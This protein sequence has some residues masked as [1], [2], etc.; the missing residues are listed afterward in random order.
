MEVGSSTFYHPY[1]NA[2]ILVI[3][4]LSELEN[5]DRIGK[6]IEKTGFIAI[7]VGSIA[8][9]I[10][11]IR[12]MMDR[13]FNQP[14]EIKMKDWNQ[15]SGKGYW[16]PGRETAA[17]NKKPDL[18]ES[19]FIPFGFKDWPKDFEGFEEAVTPFQNEMKKITLKFMDCMAK[20][21]NTK[22]LQS[23]DDIQ[24]NP[25]NLTRLAFYPAPASTDDPEAIRA[26][27]HTDLNALTFLPSSSPGLQL[28]DTDGNWK[29]VNVTEDVILV[30]PGDQL[31]HLTGGKIKAVW[32]RVL[33][34]TGEYAAKSRNAVIFFAAFNPDFSLTPLPNCIE[35]M[36]KNMSDDEKA[37]YLKQYPANVTVHETTQSRLMEMGTITDPTLDEVK[38]L[39]DKG[40]LRKPPI[41]LVNKYPEVLT[42]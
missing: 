40:L 9:V 7:K 13:Y 18:K 21:L 27:A 34:P 2:D 41:A 5:A 3:D 39:R 30:N 1:Q 26:G 37:E 6:A 28:R 24:N 16:E 33:N 35:E 11:N 15:N 38:K 10:K 14:L 4:D 19:F 8:P 32:H 23:S 25:N 29:N 22:E 17:G 31:E 42:L 12:E 20:Y 36:T